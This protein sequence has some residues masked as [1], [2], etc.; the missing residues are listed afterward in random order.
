MTQREHTGAGVGVV[1]AASRGG[2]MHAKADRTSVFEQLICIASFTSRADE[3]D[4][5]EAAANTTEKQMRCAEHNAVFDCWLSLKLLD[6]LADLDVCAADQGWSSLEIV[7]H[8]IQTRYQQRL[9]PTEALQ[10]QRD[11]FE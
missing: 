3:E 11:L 5:G 10:P 7:R 8:C 1:L 9:I 6:K 2:I 4:T